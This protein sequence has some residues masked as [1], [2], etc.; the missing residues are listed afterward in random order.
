MLSSIPHCKVRVLLENKKLHMHFEHHPGRDK[1]KLSLEGVFEF[2][3]IVTPKTR[4]VIAVAISLV[5]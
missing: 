3:G 5:G 4:L 1:L 2:D